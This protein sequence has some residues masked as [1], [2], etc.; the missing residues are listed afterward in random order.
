VSEPA[1]TLACSES[2]DT[3]ATRCRA[4]LDEHAE[5]RID[6]DRFWGTGPDTVPIFESPGDEEEQAQLIVARA[7]QR[8]LFD[9]GLA[10]IDGPPDYGGAGL[11]AAHQQAL[12]R[13][14]ADYQLPNLYTLFVGLNIIAPGI[15]AGA[16]EELKRQLLPKIYRADVIA[17]QLF[18]EPGAG[19]DLAAV[20]TRATRIDSDGST[21]WEITGQ[22]VWTSGGHY[23]DIGL[24][25]ARTDDG[26]V[27]HRRL[28]MFVVDMHDPRVQIRR[29]REMSGGATFNEIFVDQLRVLDDARVGEVGN[30][31][32]VAMATLGGER[33]AVGDSD[34][35]PNREV[36]RRLIDLARHVHASRGGLDDA[37]RDAVMRCYALG[38]ALERTADRLGAV[39]PVGPE[40][41]VVKLLRNRFLRAC[42]DTAGNLLGPAMTADTGAWGTFAWGRA[43]TL[44]PG[45]RIGGGT[46]EIQR[47]ILG[48]RVLGLP[49]EP[50][51][52]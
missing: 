41:S 15:L 25:L 23:S 39:S 1:A 30:G 46:D 38:L 28:T 14:A 26:P 24:L 2:L 9:V 21:C 16:S 18:S 49:K 50:R 17:C 11:T 43:A 36:V 51:L 27:P 48:E 5:R 31:W 44:A 45:L 3:F 40:M 47:N 52:R 12:N 35:A 22:K 34:D 29:L 19:S 32:S 13:I 4:F 10:W 7:W 42:T 33:K 20:S 37:T 8:A 6:R